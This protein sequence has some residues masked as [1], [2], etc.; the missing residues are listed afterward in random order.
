MARINAG[1]G[2]TPTEGWLNFD[3]SLSLRLAKIPVLPSI[4][5]R[6][7]FLN[8]SQYQFVRFARENEI[9]YG[10]VV[11]GL[12]VPDQSCE[13]LYSSH[14]IEHLDRI[15]VANFLDQTFRILCGGGII[16][17]AAPNIKAQV[18]QYI[19]SGDADAF[20]KGTLMCVARPRSI[21][22]R[23]QLLFVGTRHHQWMDDGD[24]LVRQWQEHGFVSAEVM[25]AG[26][27][28]IDDHQPLDLCERDSQSVYVEAEKPIG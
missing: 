18:D 11:K 8:D 25:P 17:I 3:N 5:R 20:V 24:S 9:R 2:R 14:M 28:K 21:S 22:Q 1:C 19:E 16:R 23:L 6:L 12:P 7:R 15:E 27:T 10:D 4:L 13:V 26:Q